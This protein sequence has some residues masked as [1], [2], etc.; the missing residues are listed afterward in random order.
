M[1]ALSRIA[2]M[3]LTFETLPAL[4]QEG[5]LPRDE[6]APSPPLGAALDAFRD[7]I[8]QLKTRRFAQVTELMV[9]RLAGADDPLNIHHDLYQK[10]SASRIEVKFCVVRQKADDRIDASNVLQVIASAAAQNRRVEFAD[11]SAHQFSCNIQ[12]VKRDEFDM[13]YYGLFFDDIVQVFRISS[14]LINEQV[15]FSKTQH[16]GNIGEGQFHITHHNLHRH[17]EQFHF[18]ALTYRDVWTLLA[19]PVQTTSPTVNEAGSVD[20]SHGAD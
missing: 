16:K 19:P 7:G 12:Q 2:L 6:I 15:S 20:E 11:W 9:R 5:S 3:P 10:G 18:C 4:A 14:A 13:L 1:D 8:F 17:L